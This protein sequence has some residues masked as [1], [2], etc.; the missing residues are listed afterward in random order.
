M[1][2]AR[3]IA[4]CY[5]PIVVPPSCQRKVFDPKMQKLDSPKTSDDED[6]NSESCKNDEKSSP[7]TGW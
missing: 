1:D 6:S 5:F 7:E 3:V 2:D 4:T